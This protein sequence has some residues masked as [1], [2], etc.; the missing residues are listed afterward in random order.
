[1]MI[2]IQCIFS[3]TFTIWFDF[4]HCYDKSFL[5]YQTRGQKMRLGYD[6]KILLF[7]FL[8]FVRDNKL[9]RV[10]LSNCSFYHF[11]NASF[12]QSWTETV[13]RL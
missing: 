5:F 11:Q 7:F 12:K 1:M 2:S 4:I 9:Y 6:V 10:C 3:S 13:V 8:S